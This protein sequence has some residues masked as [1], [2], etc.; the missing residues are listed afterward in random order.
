MPPI[1]VGL[2]RDPSPLPL[3]I[4]GAE[5]GPLIDE[6]DE[7]KNT[8]EFKLDVS[9]ALLPIV[10][11]VFDRDDKLFVLPDKDVDV[12][13]T[14]VEEVNVEDGVVV[15][16]AILLLGEVEVLT[17]VTF[18]VVFVVLLVVTAGLNAL[19]LFNKVHPPFASN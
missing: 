3:R 9:V 1:T 13:P 10:D 19:G 4:N 14:L 5:E 12:V 6:K 18:V 16:P 2:K 17:V 11:G 7:D 8:E 15:P